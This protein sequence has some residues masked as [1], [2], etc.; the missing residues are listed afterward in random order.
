[1][2]VAQIEAPALAAMLRRRLAELARLTPEE[3][4]RLI[5][6]KGVERR[7]TAPPPRAARKGPARPEAKLLAMVLHQPDLASAIPLDV[8]SGSGPEVSALRAVVGLLQR[9][10]GLNLGQVSAYFDG[11]EHQDA[12]TEAFADP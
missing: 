5:P 10:P 2:L 1:P 11:G 8:L 6:S 9:Q 7:P 4:E 12:I 3:I